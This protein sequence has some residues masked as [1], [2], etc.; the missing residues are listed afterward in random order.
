[1]N[2]LPNSDDFIHIEKRPRDEFR[3]SQVIIWIY[4]RKDLSLQKM[5]HTQNYQQIKCLSSIKT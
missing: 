4:E 5:R 1:M 2:S 3:N